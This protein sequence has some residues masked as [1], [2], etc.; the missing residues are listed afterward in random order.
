MPD[1]RVLIV[2]ALLQSI[3][4]ELDISPTK[5][6]QAVD[7]Y[8][9]VGRWLEGGTYPGAKGIP[10]IYTQGSF[11]LGTV[12]R[13]LK[14]G[15]ERE[16]DIDLACQLDMNGSVTAKDL[17]HSIGDRLKESG[18]YKKCLSRRGGGAGRSSTPRTTVSAFISTLCLASQ[19]R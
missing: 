14:G 9:T 15:E 7:R 4:E 12:V 2:D 19:S 8:E 17:K 13:P 18:T 10:H 5:Y 11:R 6:A 3:A 16:Y 1:N